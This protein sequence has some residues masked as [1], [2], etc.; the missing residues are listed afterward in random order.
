MQCLITIEDS[1]KSNFGGG[2]R[3]TLEVLRTIYLK[4]LFDRI[5][6]VDTKKDSHFKKKAQCYI[7]DFIFIKTYGKI[8][9]KDS[10]SFNIGIDEM[11]ISF[12]YL[13][14]NIFSL[15]KRIKL[16]RSYEIIIYATTK[17]ALIY[18]LLLKLFFRF[19]VIFHAHSIDNRRSFFYLTYKFLY[20]KC[21]IIICVS[22]FSYR[23]INLQSAI[24]INNPIYLKLDNVKSKSIS[25]KLIIASFSNLLKWKGIEYFMKS[26]NYLH[27]KDVEYWVFGDGN[28]KKYLKSLEQ[29]NVKL[30][31]FVSDLSEVLEKVSIVVVP[32]ISEESFGMVIIEALAYGIPVITTNIGAQAELVINNMNGFHVPIKDSISIAGRIDYL[33]ANPELYKSLSINAIDSV[34]KYNLNNFEGLIVE[35]FSGSKVI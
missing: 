9:S 20:S 1:S 13:F 27:H 18:A 12:Y 34:K 25:N 35:T 32:T 15:I 3:I 29:S 28:E 6:L 26:Y 17:K 11:I 24:L 7:S 22:E 10:P 30:K 8:K 16:L 23:K 14:V 4:R 2:Q 33:I 19:P 21:D 5:V 31:G